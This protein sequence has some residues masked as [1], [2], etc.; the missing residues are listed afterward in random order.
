MI[1]ITILL[2][3]LFIHQ[4]VRLGRLEGEVAKLKSQPHIFTPSANQVVSNQT[5]VATESQ[6]QEIY[7]E[8]AKTDIP[9]YASVSSPVDI[10]S[11]VIATEK[12]EADNTEFTFGTQIISGVGILAVVL[13]VGFF[14]RYAFDTGLITVGMRLFLGFLLGLLSLGAG[15][16]LSKKFASYGFGLIGLALASWYVTA[17]AA[18]A[19]YGVISEPTSMLL[20]VIITAIGICLSIAYNSESLIRFSLLGGYIVPFIFTGVDSIHF[21]FVY[22]II[23]NLSVLIIARFKTW[24]KLTMF[25][26]V[27]TFFISLMLSSTEAAKMITPQA[28][29]YLTI[30]FLI[31]LVSSVKN[32]LYNNEDHQ[33]VNALLSYGIPVFYFLCG[34]PLLT[35]KD[36]Y[37]LLS[38]FIGIF[39][40]IFS[41]IFRVLFNKFKD[42]EIISN[43]LA[44]IGSMFL[45]LATALHFEGRTLDMFLITEAIILVVI[46]SLMKSIGHRIIGILLAGFMALK[47]FS[48][49]YVFSDNAVALFNERALEFGYITIAYAIIWYV[50]KFFESRDLFEEKGFGGIVSSVGLFFIP[51]IWV[52]LEVFKFGPVNFSNSLPILWSLYALLFITASFLCKEFLFRVLS[53]AVLAGSVLVMVVAMW[54]LASSDYT[55]IFNIRLLSVLVIL[56]VLTLVLAM[57]RSY[58]NDLTEDELQI[59]K[60]F[61]FII[62]GILLWGLSLEVVDYYNYQIASSAGNADESKSLENTKRVGLSILWL[63]YASVSIAYGIIKRNPIIRQASIVLLAVTVFKIFLYDTTNLDDIYRFISFITLGVI[64]LLVGFAYNRFK[65][66]I[67]EFVGVESANKLD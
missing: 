64:L 31:Y 48:N 11:P 3:L 36:E 49:N 51:F 13:G 46:G 10:S 22:L 61:Y 20:S 7:S 17:Y 16:I 30:L 21:K 14:L 62:N 4:G 50:Y 59:S 55:P 9:V 39:Y 60:P 8:I 2:F 47:V 28:F 44:T 35:N 38:L 33:S 56:T 32:V 18:F 26:L 67:I 57:I 58:K 5:P 15:H 1:L 42:F 12:K 40:V 23:L 53:Y 24:P 34:M 6:K 37:T 27:F 65:S 19:F 25:G 29:V 66:R 43:V 63:V 52:N 45:L 41:I 54:S